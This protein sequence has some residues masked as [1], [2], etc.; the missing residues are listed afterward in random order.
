M[1][2][3][4]RKQIRD[5]AIARLAGLATTAARVYAGRVKVLQETELPC[6]LVDTG[7]EQIVDGSRQ[8]ERALARR[9]V[10]LRVRCVVKQVSGYLDTLDQIAQEVEIALATAATLGGAKGWW[11][12]GTTAPELDGDGDRPVA[13]LELAFD[14]HYATTE[15]T[16]DVAA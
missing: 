9:I 2:D 8:F 11:L 12:T 10:Q 13:V 3:H 14:V 1:A 4:V 7:D 5:A 15:A 6:L 16:P